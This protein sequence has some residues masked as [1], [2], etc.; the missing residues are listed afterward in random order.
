[1]GRRTHDSATDDVD[2]EASTY[3]SIGTQGG[4][5]IGAYS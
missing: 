4:E 1:M 5:E 2:G 3:V